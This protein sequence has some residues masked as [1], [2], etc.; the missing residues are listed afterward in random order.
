MSRTGIE[1]V[2]IRNKH[3]VPHH[4]VR[5]AC[6][7][8]VMPANGLVYAPQHPCACYLEAKLS[9]FNALAPG[10]RNKD[11]AQGTQG[12]EGARGTE[13]ADR[14]EEGPAYEE[15]ISNQSPVIS[16]Q[17]ADSLNTDHRSLI[18]GDWPTYRH[19]AA[20]SGFTKSPVSPDLRQAWRTDIGG[21]LSAVTVAQGKL[22]VASVD[23]H[24]VHALDAASGKQLWRFTAGGRV[25]SPPT[26]DAGRVLFGSADGWVYCLRASDGILAWRFRAAPT[27]QRLMAFEQLESVWPVHGSVLVREGVLY[28]VSGRS[29]FL[30]GGL[31]LWRLDPNTGNVLS[32]TVLDDR[33][34]VSGKDLQSYV[35][36]LNMPTG[37]PDILSSDHRYV[38]MR[39]QPF[40]LDGTRLPLEAMPTTGDADRGAPPA[41]QNPEYAHLF[42]P[43]GFLDDS[44][45]H[46]TY[47]MFGSRF[48]SGWCGYFRAGKATPAGRILVFDDSRLYGFG[49]KPKYYR[50]TTPIEHHLFRTDKQPPAASQSASTRPGESKYLVTH[51]WS[52]DL[53]L[54]ARAMLLADR[55]LF[56]AGP[57]DTL[58]EEQ[59]LRQIND[60]AVAASLADQADALRGTSEALLWAVSAEDG[61]KLAQHRLD[62]SP[63]FDGMAAAHGRLYLAA[64]DGRVVCL[65]GD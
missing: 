64:T 65:T 48:V 27:A 54:F 4:W 55:T 3:W 5:G 46:R 11:D 39:S 6:L 30:D 44:W 8:G 51:H 24:T 7:Y 63:V 2:D 36:W 57:A 9:G 19:D 13:A 21:K 42:S 50:W 10:Q 16:G 35:S 45:W 61:T 25:D 29:M 41:T 34:D 37:L 32:E 23:A 31:R 62:A 60:P 14:L 26:V 47:W 17:A 18:T 40:Q 58:D 1:F 20:R 33:V 38:F 22:F 49:R 12:T 43:T 28:C 53:P 56:V 15:V 59:A 52:Q